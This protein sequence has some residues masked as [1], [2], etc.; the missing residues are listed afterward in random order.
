MEPVSNFHY[1]SLEDPE[2]CIRLLQ[3]VP[4]CDGKD[5]TLRGVLKGFRRGVAPPYRPVSYTWG[6]QDASSDLLLQNAG[7]SEWSHFAIRPNLETLL[8]QI[9]STLDSAFIWVDAICINQTDNLEKG[10]Q[11]RNMDKVYR[12]QRTIVWLGEPGSNSDLALDLIEQYRAIA[13]GARMGQPLPP[14]VSQELTNLVN[15]PSISTESWHALYDLL[16]RPWFSRRW[17]VQEFVLSGHQDFWIGPRRQCAFFLVVLIFLIKGW[18]RHLEEGRINGNRCEIDGHVHSLASPDPDPIEKLKDLWDAHKASTRGDTSAFT[19]DR[20]LDKFSAFDS[21]DPRDGIYAFISMASDIDRS[22]WF[23]D[24]SDSNSTMNLY[25]KAVLH[26]MRTRQSTDVVCRNITMQNPEFAVGVSHLSTWIPWFGLQTLELEPFTCNHGHHSTEIPLHA[27]Q[28]QGYRKTSLTTYGQ[29]LGRLKP[30]E[31]GWRRPICDGCERVI[32]GSAGVQCLDCA[33][34]DY[35][36]LCARR[37]D[38]THDAK[39]RFQLHNGAV[40]FAS[41]SSTVRTNLQEPLSCSC[42]NQ[43]CPTPLAFGCH[44]VDTVRH[45]ADAIPRTR[46]D[47]GSI[48]VSLPISSWLKLPGFKE[49]T[50]ENGIPDESVCRTL[51]GNRRVVGGVVCYATDSWIATVRNSLRRDPRPETRSIAPG[52]DQQLSDGESPDLSTWESPSFMVSEPRTLAI[53]TNSLGLVPVTSQPGDRVAILAGCSVPVILRST[54]EIHGR[55]Y[56]NLIGE[57]YI[58]GIMDGEFMESLP[59]DWKWLTIGIV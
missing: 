56:W 52:E 36:Y 59:E 54:G 30:G 7:E 10:Y 1:I 33:D 14:E 19:L 3:L 22:E 4:A 39:H 38:V 13:K 41:M 26:I 28:M 37:L 6:T 21:F 44:F 58:D 42:P 17:I 2:D 15:S 29:P 47:R 48:M 8:K 32:G 23:P 5:G 50:D 25:G 9:R 16:L 45:V 11:V 40:Y 57:C 27:H 24:Y 20:L 53:T 34:F 46:R 31:P 55:E 49:R 35:C 43:S 51:T 12:N 18:P